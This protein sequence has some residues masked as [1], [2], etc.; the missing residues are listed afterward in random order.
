[1]GMKKSF[2][3]A[4]LDLKLTLSSTIRVLER[5]EARCLFTITEMVQR[6]GIE[7]HTI[8]YY[9]KIGLLPPAK[10]RQGKNRTYTDTDLRFLQF[11]LSLKQTGMSLDDMKEFVKEGCILEREIPGVEEIIIARRDI[12]SKH[13]GKLEEQF[14]QLEQIIALTKEKIATYDALLVDRQEG[15]EKS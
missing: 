10:R 15:G 5:K 3:M 13:M 8:R 14:H 1:M 9:E 2:L 6:T 11:I 7:A 4:Q 12:L